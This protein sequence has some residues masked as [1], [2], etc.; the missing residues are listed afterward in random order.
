MWKCWVE[1]WNGRNKDH[2]ER[3]RVLKIVLQ[4]RSLEH[5]SHLTWPQKK[6]SFSFFVSEF[7]FY[8]CETLFAVQNLLW[9]QNWLIMNYALISYHHITH[10]RHLSDNF[11]CCNMN[12]LSSQILHP[13]WQGPD[14]LEHFAKTFYFSRVSWLSISSWLK[15]CNFDSIKVYLCTISALDLLFSPKRLN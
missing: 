1:N 13:W 8:H 14:Q 12:P 11:S 6:E 4:T 9:S 10:S 3:W 7:V 2:K 15:I 5:S